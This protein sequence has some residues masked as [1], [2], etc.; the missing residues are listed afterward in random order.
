[1]NLR[2]W[3]VALCCAA[4]LAA[5]PILAADPAAPGPSPEEMAMMEAYMKAAT[6]GPMH[7]LLKQSVGTYDLTVTSWMAPGTPP[8]IS[9]A[10]AERTFVLGRFV[11]EK[12]KGDAMFP[13]GPAFEGMG[14]SGYDNVSQAFFSTWMDNMGTGI[15]MSSGTYDERSKTFDYRGTYNDPLTGKPKTVRMTVREIDDAT[16]VFEM[17]DKGPDGKEFKSMEI[18]YAKR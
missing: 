6:P 16:S 13:G 8:Q 18:K 7:E 11:I 4:A 5:S 15:M 3:I 1:M 2:P 14:I 9:Q 17:Y 12:T 10:T